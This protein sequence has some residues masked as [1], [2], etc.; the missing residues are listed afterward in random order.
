MNSKLLSIKQVKERVPV[1]TSS[2]YRGMEDGRFPLPVKIGGR[3]F[4]RSI[5]IDRLVETGSWV[6]RRGRPRST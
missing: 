6:P 1:A 3:V 4:W 2:W 5:D